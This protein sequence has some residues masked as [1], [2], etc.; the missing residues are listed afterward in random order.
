[1][2]AALV[3]VPRAC[4][5]LSI[6]TRTLSRVAAYAHL[7]R[8]AALG[9]LWRCAS[10]RGKHND[11]ERTKLRASERACV[12]SF[13]RPGLALETGDKEGVS[14]AAIMIALSASPTPLHRAALSTATAM[15]AARMHMHSERGVVSLPH[16]NVRS[17]THLTCRLA[18]RKP[19]FL[20]LRI[21]RSFGDT[22]AS[23]AEQYGLRPSPETKRTHC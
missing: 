4:A 11:G 8:N 22:C 20:K 6:A 15:H 16:D 18:G 23:A 19:Q 7:H 2:P 9:S 13:V 17:C 3:S 1:M 12:R 21:S 10:C 14:T 5:R